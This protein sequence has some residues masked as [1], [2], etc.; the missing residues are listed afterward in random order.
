M[1]CRETERIDEAFTFL[2]ILLVHA[3]GQRGSILW[4]LTSSY[5]PRKYTAIG[6]ILFFELAEAS[7]NINAH[8]PAAILVS[9]SICFSPPCYPVLTSPQYQWTTKRIIS[10][11]AAARHRAGIQDMI[12]SAAAAARYCPIKLC[13]PP[14]YER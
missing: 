6:N 5:S 3:A 2:L 1:K 7:S 13:S 8:P 11:S 4:Y 9:V 12:S 14:G 10:F